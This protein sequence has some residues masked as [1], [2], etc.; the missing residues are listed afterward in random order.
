M[1]EPFICAE[2]GR[3]YYRRTSNACCPGCNSDYDQGVADAEA[4]LANRE[5]FGQEFAD[6]V[7]IERELREGE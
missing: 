7:E 3:P 4:Y 6:A 2:C 5:A 1:C